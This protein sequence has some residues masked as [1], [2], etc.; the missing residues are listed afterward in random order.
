MSDHTY[1]DD[2]T[3]LPQ[4]LERTLEV[5][6]DKEAYRYY[7]YNREVWTSVSCR[8]FGARVMRWRKAFTAMG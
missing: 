8:E 2:F 7:D 5:K 1:I 4:M 6:P 3:T